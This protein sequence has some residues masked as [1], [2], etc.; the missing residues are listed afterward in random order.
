MVER[1]NK[2]ENI[3]VCG[4]LMFSMYSVSQPPPPD[5]FWHFFPNGWEFLVNL[6]HILLAYYTFQSTLDYTFLFNYLQ[7]SGSYAIFSASTQRAYQP[8]V[9]IL[10]I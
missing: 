5:V 1:A 6:V 7:F 10:S 3:G 4:F 9:D 8:M 2:L